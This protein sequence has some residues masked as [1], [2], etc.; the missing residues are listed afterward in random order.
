[1]KTNRLKKAIAISLITIGIN[2]CTTVETV[3]VTNPLERPTRPTLPHI[4][5]AEA[6]QVPEI[7]WAKVVE[8]MRLVRQYAEKLEV[9]IDSTKEK[10]H[11]N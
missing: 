8:R 3:Y 2:A 10:Q 4:T 9:I 5:G 6:E 7:T 11:G 1:M